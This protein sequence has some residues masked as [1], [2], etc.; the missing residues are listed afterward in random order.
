MTFAREKGVSFTFFCKIT[1]S[2]FCTIPILLCTVISSIWKISFSLI[3][4]KIDSHYF[5]LCQSN[6]LILNFCVVQLQLFPV[7]PHHSL[8]PCPYTT[9]HIQSPAPRPLGFVHG[10]CT[11]VPWLYPS[12][13]FHLL[14]PSPLPA[15]HC[16][17]AL[18]FHVS[19]SILVTCF[20]GWLD[21]T[22]RWIYG[23]CLSL[24]G[25]FHLA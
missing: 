4:S 15:G 10:S 9:F 13:S 20:F 21:S 22:Y 6:S 12:P 18:Y 2:V 14:S 19:G 16:Q 8:L 3:P 17:F 7:F 24:P 1:P 23:M 25:L 11:H 5:Y